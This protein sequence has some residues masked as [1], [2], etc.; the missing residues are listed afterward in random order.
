MALTIASTRTFPHF[1]SRARCYTRRVMKKLLGFIVL[2]AIAAG[3]TWFAAGREAGPRIDIVAPQTAIGRA[4]SITLVIDS[5]GGRLN[6][7]DVS[8]EQGKTSAPIFKL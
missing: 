3:L 7:L 1:R 5:P 2:L 8:L 6:G 4:G